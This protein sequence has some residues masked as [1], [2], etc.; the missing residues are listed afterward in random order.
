MQSDEDGIVP[1]W[2]DQANCDGR[3]R[4]ENNQG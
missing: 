4:Q 1:Q 3:F 2:L